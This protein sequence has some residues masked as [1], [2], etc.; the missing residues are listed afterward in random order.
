MSSRPAAVTAVDSPEGS[1][2]VV[3]ATPPSNVSSPST[4]T[5]NLPLQIASTS[6][7]YFRDSS[8][9][10]QGQ[11][12]SIRVGEAPVALDMESFMTLDF[13]GAGGF[14]QAFPTNL[15]SGDQPRPQGENN[16]IDRQSLPFYSP[17]ITQVTATRENYLHSNTERQTPVWR[18][19]FQITASKRAEL[20]REMDEVFRQV[21]IPAGH[22]LSN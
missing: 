11:R 20:T 17:A 4:T 12:E 15:H 22:V 2:I 7:Q 16:T 5:G 14:S 21:S 6:A 10:Q 9:Q 18:S 3:N 19:P 8:P 1:E 13:G